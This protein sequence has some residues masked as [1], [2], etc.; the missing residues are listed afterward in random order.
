MAR[1]YKRTHHPHTPTT[2]TTPKPNPKTDHHLLVFQRKVD[3]P[4]KGRLALLQNIDVY[5][6][7]G[8]RV[9]PSTVTVA[10]DGKNVYVVGANFAIST[11]AI[12]VYRWVRM[13]MGGWLHVRRATHADIWAGSSLPIPSPHQPLL[14]SHFPNTQTTASTPPPGS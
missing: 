14:P 4:E 7:S 12:L 6:T 5:N 11:S 8:S 2:H 10:P 1:I 3:G 9:L 13:R